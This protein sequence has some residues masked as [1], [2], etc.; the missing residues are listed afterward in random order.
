MNKLP[1]MIKDVIIGTLLGDSKMEFTRSTGTAR[2]IYE[3]SIKHKTYLD[4]VYTI[5]K[6]YTVKEP[7]EYKHYDKRTDKSTTSY[8]FSTITSPLFYPFADLF[9]TS[10][11]N[12]RRVIKVLPSMIDELLTPCAL[13]Y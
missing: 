4:F 8:R 7:K 9:Y 3:L 10:I 6:D 12:S 5:F 1:P 13:A 2:F 11:P